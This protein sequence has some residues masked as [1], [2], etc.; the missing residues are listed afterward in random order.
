MQSMQSTGTFPQRRPAEIPTGYKTSI[1]RALPCNPTQLF[2]YWE[3]PPSSGSC[4]SLSLSLI[5]AD[6]SRTSDRSPYGV[7]EVPP[8][9]S[10]YYLSVPVPGLSCLVQ[11]D[12]TFTDGKHLVLQSEQCVHVPSPLGSSGTSVRSPI[13]TPQM[14]P[15]AEGAAGN[16]PAV[17]AGQPHL[18]VKPGSHSSGTLQEFS[19]P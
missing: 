18:T 4:T 5:E 11:L 3:L 19:R 8:A 6:T 7:I 1:L 17:A 16:M 12:A 9:S 2:V 14:P 13:D 15:P 10:S